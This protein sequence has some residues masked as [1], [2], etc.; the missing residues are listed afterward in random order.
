MATEA[1]GT[2]GHPDD[3]PAPGPGWAKVWNFFDGLGGV[4]DRV[5]GIT[6]D[7]AGAAERTA[8]AK[9]AWQDLQEREQRADT[10]DLLRRAGFARGD[11]VKLYWVVG[12]V[13]AVGLL[14]I[15]G[16]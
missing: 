12:G 5:G 11:N 6:E 4:A 14:A 7:I 15:L 2:V 9:L 10:D 3:E 16:K 8:G 13:A 1:A